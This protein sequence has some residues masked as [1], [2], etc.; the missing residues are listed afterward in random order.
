MATFKIPGTIKIIAAGLLTAAFYAVLYSY[1]MFSPMP[2]GWGFWYMFAAGMLG[3]F[4][5]GTISW[6]WTRSII[7]L[8]IG[9]AIGII[10]GGTWTEVA[11][12]DTRIGVL[13]GAWSYLSYL[14]LKDILLFFTASIPFATATTL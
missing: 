10:A 8:C 3:S 4:A 12:S 14:G 1:F 9:T 11:F 7:A 6:I 13:M 2:A 5:A